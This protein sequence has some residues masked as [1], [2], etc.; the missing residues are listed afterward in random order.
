[1][2]N[3]SAWAFGLYFK[4]QKFLFGVAVPDVAEGQGKESIPKAMSQQ[5]LSTLN[6]MIEPLDFSINC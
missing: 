6:F 3:W 2:G 4:W 1:M 5:I